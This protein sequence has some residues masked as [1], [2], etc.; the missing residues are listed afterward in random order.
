MIDLP[1]QSAMY[2]DN[3]NQLTENLRSQE[4]QFQVAELLDQYL[5]KPGNRLS[6]VPST[7]G[8]TDPTLLELTAGYNKLVVD[9]LNELQTGATLNSPIV[10]NLKKILKKQE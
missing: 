4:V 1:A 3:I 10:K 6:L 9:R 2:L 7:L 5:N 8:L